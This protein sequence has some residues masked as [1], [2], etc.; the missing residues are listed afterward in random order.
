[1][2][3]IDLELKVNSLS[4]KT[5]HVPSDGSIKIFQYKYSTANI[6]NKKTTKRK[7]TF[8]FESFNSFPTIT[9]V[10][11]AMTAGP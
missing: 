1:V 10:A 7:N 4:L 8:F 6:K 2:C 11:K 9:L 3:D 5:Y